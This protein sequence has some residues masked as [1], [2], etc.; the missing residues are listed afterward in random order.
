MNVLKWLVNNAD[1]LEPL[2]M[3]LE[4]WWENFFK[5]IF[6]AKTDSKLQPAVSIFCLAGKNPQHCLKEKF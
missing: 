6:K 2:L 4:N 5:N 3:S 1:L